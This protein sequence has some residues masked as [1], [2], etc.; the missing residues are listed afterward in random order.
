MRTVFT[1]LAIGLAAALMDG[2][3]A[4]SQDTSEWEDLFAKD[5]RDWSRF[6][7]GEN[8]WQLTADRS[9]AC[10]GG[11]EIFLP[12]RDFA[13]GTLRFEYRFRPTYKK[14]PYEAAVWVRRTVSGNGC[15]ISLGEG[16]GKL[17]A[18]VESGSDRKKTFAEGPERSPAKKI[19][20]WNE[21][22]LILLDRTVSVRVNGKE[23]AAFG[24]CDTNRGL[25]ALEAEGSALEFRRVMWKEGK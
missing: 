10:S 16:C 18:T 23:V 25:F 20:L 15:K 19:G 5:F 8:P 14:A 11:N 13:N 7:S 1:T 22:E 9:L 6:G 21:V 2:S 4:V 17:T 12:E 3:H 24:N